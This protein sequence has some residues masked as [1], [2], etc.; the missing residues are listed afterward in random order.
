MSKRES[1]CEIKEAEGSVW[2]RGN[3]QP[4]SVERNPA[5]SSMINMCLDHPSLLYLSEHGFTVTHTIT[6]KHLI[7]HFG[8]SRGNVPHECQVTRPVQHFSQSAKY[9]SS[10]YRLL[11]FS[12]SIPVH[13]R[14]ASFAAEPYTYGANI[15]A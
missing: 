2:E 10:F 1:V 8:N 3:S 15:T 5:I 11:F 7:H 14:I 4:F 12:L 6:H 9:H 13:A